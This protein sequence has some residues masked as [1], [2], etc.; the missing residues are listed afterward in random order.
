M[1]LYPRHH[2]PL[3]HLDPLVHAMCAV[4]QDIGPRNALNDQ[5]DLK[6]GQIRVGGTP[7]AEVG[8]TMLF[9]SGLSLLTA[10][11]IAGVSTADKQIISPQTAQSD[12]GGRKF[13]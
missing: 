3:V 6:A 10:Q 7:M 4:S 13:T 1:L 12:N 5:M 2:R 11:R 8:T 9:A